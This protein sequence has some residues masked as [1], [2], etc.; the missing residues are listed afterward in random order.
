MFVSTKT[1][2]Q[3]AA[4]EKILFFPSTS[5]WQILYAGE[6]G[7]GDTARDRGCVDAL[8][9][10]CCGDAGEGESVGEGRV[11]GSCGIDEVDGEG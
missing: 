3:V 4:N 9:G 5:M 2:I 6:H 10:E 7:R 8:K 11:R 1:T